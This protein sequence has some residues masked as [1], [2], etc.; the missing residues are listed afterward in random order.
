MKYNF[1]I[2]RGTGDFFFLYAIESTTNREFVIAGY[3]DKKFANKIKNN[4][5]RNISK[6]KLE[7]WFDLYDKNQYDKIDTEI[8]Q[9]A[10]HLEIT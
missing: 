2:K 7:K 5:K 1:E 6:K 4:L 9:I 8:E 10:N 3:R